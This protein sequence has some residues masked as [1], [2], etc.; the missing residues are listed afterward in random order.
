MFY[1]VSVVAQQDRHLRQ[2]SDQERVIECPI[3]DSAFEVKSEPMKDALGYNKG[4]SR[5]GRMKEEG[6]SKD[7]GDYDE[8]DK[9]SKE[10]EGMLSAARAWMEITSAKS[11]ASSNLQVGELAVLAVKCTLP[12]LFAAQVVL[13]CLLIDGS[14]KLELVG[15]WSIVQPT[16]GWGSHP[17]NCW[18]KKGVL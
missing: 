11:S 1:T 2:I 4:S 10:L 6:W 13:L 3:E 18:M 9:S 7:F 8:N 5:T 14:L 12:G 15:K 16:M 17:R